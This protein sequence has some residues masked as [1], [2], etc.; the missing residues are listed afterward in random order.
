LR[1]AKG[2]VFWSCCAP[3]DAVS[4]CLHSAGVPDHALRRSTRKLACAKLEYAS[5]DV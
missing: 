1:R 4:A 2:K 5:K 3:F